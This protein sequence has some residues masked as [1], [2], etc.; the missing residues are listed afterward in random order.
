MQLTVCVIHPKAVTQRI[1]VIAFAGKHFTRHAQGI[2]YAVHIVGHLAQAQAFKF[3]IQ[4]T[5]IE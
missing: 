4:K 5:D 3:T 2:D 1:Q